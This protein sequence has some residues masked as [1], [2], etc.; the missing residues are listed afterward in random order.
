MEPDSLTMEPGSSTMDPG[1][2]TMDPGSPLAFE[3][4]KPNFIT[5]TCK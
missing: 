5:H 2:S 1:S 3:W 4:D